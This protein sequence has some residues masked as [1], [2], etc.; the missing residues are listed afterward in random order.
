MRKTA[1]KRDR[2]KKKKAQDRKRGI[3]SFAGM[4]FAIAAVAAA[5]FFLPQLIFYVQDNLLCRDMALG[6]RESM[7]VESLST[8]YEK[9][10][11]VRMQNFAEGVQEYKDFYVTAQELTAND[12]LSTFLNSDKGLYQN[13]MVNLVEYNLLSDALWNFT[14]Y[15]DVLWKQYVIYNDDYEEGVNFI[16]WYIEISDQDGAVLKLLFDAEDGTVY[17]I[18]A[19]GSLFYWDPYWWTEGLYIDRA[20]E[21]WAGFA[22]YYKSVSEDIWKTLTLDGEMEVEIKDMQE[23]YDATLAETKAM[24]GQK[25][26]EEIPGWKNLF[27]YQFETPDYAHFYLPYGEAVLDAVLRIDKREDPGAE[28]FNKN[29]NEIGK[30]YLYP[31]VTMGISQIYEMIPEFA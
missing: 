26:E 6:Q 1:G 5:A 24:S 17:G 16:L 27:R 30:V 9:S 12:E 15:S 11:A 31:D 25:K 23:V 7:N 4:S 19:E 8:T 10:L 21:I 22:L 3:S 28:S 13:V 14:D 20:M 29:K 2:I 18:K